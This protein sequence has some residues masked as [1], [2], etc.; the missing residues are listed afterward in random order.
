MGYKSFEKDNEIFFKYISKRKIFKSSKTN[1][2]NSDNVFGV[3][4]NINFK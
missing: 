4:R 3:L 2:L 1:K